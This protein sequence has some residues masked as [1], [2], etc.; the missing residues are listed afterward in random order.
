MK[1]KK[2]LIIGGVGLAIVACLYFYKKKSKKI[3]NLEDV[4][5]TDI[6]E[7]DL[8]KKQVQDEIDKLPYHNDLAE[9]IN[10]L[11]KMIDKMNITDAK[12]YASLILPMIKTGKSTF[13]KNS[14][15]AKYDALALKYGINQFKK[16]AQP[17]LIDLT[18]KK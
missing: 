1:T 8:L 4:N 3:S 16:S 9:G 14:D 15:Q 7:K 6:S 10:S 11:N 12:E 5:P 17:T 18:T 13:I 2:I